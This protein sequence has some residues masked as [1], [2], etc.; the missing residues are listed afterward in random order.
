MNAAQQL[1]AARKL[2][3]DPKHWT[4]NV[5]A[6]NRQRGEEV[7]SRSPDARCWCAVGALLHVIFDEKDQVSARRYLAAASRGLSPNGG[8]IIVND[9]RSRAEAHPRVLAMYDR[10]IELATA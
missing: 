9:S 6:R 4:Q 3:E 10:A 2:I 7:A 5:C 8:I 1:E